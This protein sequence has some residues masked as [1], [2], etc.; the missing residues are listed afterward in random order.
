M[1]WWKAIIIGLFVY[2]GLFGLVFVL[3]VVFGLGYQF[4]DLANTISDILAFPATTEKSRDFVINMLFW[5]LA[6]GGS[7]KI[8]DIFRRSKPKK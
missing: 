6:I 7:I 5:A 2:L 3:F 4:P 1:K 8:F